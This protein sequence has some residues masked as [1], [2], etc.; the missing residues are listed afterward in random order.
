MHIEISTF[1]EEKYQYPI[2]C[3]NNQ[4]FLFS[5]KNFLYFDIITFDEKNI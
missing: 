5:L 3:Y 1:M 4:I 2:K